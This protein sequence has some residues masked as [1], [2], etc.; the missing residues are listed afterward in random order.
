MAIT[1]NNYTANGSNDTFNLTFEYLEQSH[2]KASIDGVDTTAFTL[3]T[4][5]TLKFN[6]V[7]TAGAAIRIFRRTDVDDKYAEFY[8]G[9]AIR[10]SDLNKN[11]DQ[12]LYVTQ[13]LQ[14]NALVIDGTNTMVGNLDMGGYRVINLGTPTAASHAATKDYVDASSGNGGIPGHTRWRKVASA[15]QTVF[16]GTGND[17]GTLSYSPVREQVYLNGALQQRNADYTADN[18]TSITFNV[19]LQLNDIVDVVCVNNLVSGTV[20]DA[21]NINYGGQFAG[22][23]T[24]T[25]ASKLS[26]VVSVKD[27][28]AVGDGVTDDTAAIQ[29]AINSISAGTV[30]VPIG[31]Y[32][33]SSSLSLKSNVTLECDDGAVFAPAHTSGDFA[34]FIGTVGSEYDLSVEATTG[35]TTITVSGSPGFQVGDTI[36]IVSVRNALS[37]TDTGT[38]WLGGGTVNAQYAYYAEWNTIAEDLGSGQYRLATPLLFPGYKTSA[39]GE[40]LTNRTAS[41]VKKVTP[42]ANAAWIGGK[43]IRNTAGA[44]VFYTLWAKDCN[45]SNISIERGAVLGS[46]VDIRASWN[47]TATAIAHSNDPTLAWDYNTYHGQLNRF[48]LVGTQDCGFNSVSDSYAAQ[49]VDFTYGSPTL[50]CNVRPFCRNSTFTR[51]FEGLTSHPGS[52]QESWTNNKIVDCLDDGI[53]IRGYMPVVSDNEIYSTL[54][55]TTGAVSTETYGIKLLYGGPRR[56]IVSGNTVRGFYG[57]FNVGGSATAEW[58]WSNCLVDISNNSVSHCFVGLS[59]DLNQTTGNSSHRFISYSNNLHSFM[60]RYIV[61]LSEYSAGVSV[62]GNKLLASFRYTGGGAFVAFVYAANN[63][64]G[65]TVTGNVWNRLLNSGTGYT[66]YLAYAA[67]ITDTTAF[68]AATWGASTVVE[69]NT[70]DYERADSIT[71]LI[72]NSPYQ[73]ARFTQSASTVYT[74]TSSSI[75][76]PQPRNKF[77]Y[78]RVSGNT[79]LDSILP[80]DNVIF[81]EG[82]FCYLR[83]SAGASTYTIRDITTSGISTNGFQ[84]PGNASITMTGANNIVQLVY[85]GTHWAVASSETTT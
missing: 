56:A 50:F 74:I 73:L 36:H 72:A 46:S 12:T 51:C 3:P 48:K 62:T 71:N 53:T 83:P 18:G 65:L 75:T 43:V 41:T 59:T 10:S 38:W 7:P 60:G 14:N 44:R 15:G 42:C 4:A 29:A 13:E 26:D 1:E 82:D 5:T 6:S 27:F 34:D 9:S 69:R 49:S 76:I 58:Q 16:S 67:S 68:P 84:T 47:C 81:E 78:I 2:I 63:C 30:R 55:T 24:R 80:G 32:K 40:T 22:Q 77:I 85:T 28:G 19:A 61:Y 37:R 25:V 66:Q 70:V 64:P 8:P 23:T 20:S 52:Y 57:A 54:E 11:F 45:L 31:T 33:T 35:D 39:A 79:N 17:G 21:A